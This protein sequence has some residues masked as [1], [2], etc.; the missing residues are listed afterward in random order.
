MTPERVTIFTDAQAAIRRMDSDEPGPGQRYAVQARRHIAAFR[1]ARPGIII[2]IRWCPAR[3]GIAG[4]EKADDGDPDCVN[5]NCVDTF[6][7]A[8]N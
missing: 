8:A 1:R 3:K 7:A 4:N 2:D 5:V 6:F